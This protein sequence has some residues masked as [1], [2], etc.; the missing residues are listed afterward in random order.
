MAAVPK[1]VDGVLEVLEERPI[2]AGTVTRNG[3]ESM[4]TSVLDKAGLFQAVE[5]IRKRD[6][7]DVQMVSSSSVAHGSDE[8]KQQAYLWGGVRVCWQQYCCGDS[9][10]GYPHLKALQPRDMPSAN[11]RKRLCAFLFL[12]K[13]VE[14]KVREKNKWKPNPNLAEANSGVEKRGCL[15]GRF[16]CRKSA[17]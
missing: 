17:W 10:K 13:R 2:G 15:A 4:L 11:L 16:L 7:S 12:M 3:L 6:A 8:R 9:T 5:M 1:M 14:T